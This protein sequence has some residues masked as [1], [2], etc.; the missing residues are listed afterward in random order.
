MMSTVKAALNLS[1]GVVFLAGSGCVQDCPNGRSG[2]DV[3]SSLRCVY[4]YRLVGVAVREP[5]FYGR[6]AAV[7]V[8]GWAAQYR[9]P[10]PRTINRQ[11]VMLKSVSR[12]YLEVTTKR[13]GASPSQNI[14]YHNLYKMSSISVVWVYGLL[15]VTRK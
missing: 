12:C 1:S 14:V 15:V 5:G 8:F 9:Q 13:L 7:I 11:S 10:R 4:V 3:G 2:A 6:T